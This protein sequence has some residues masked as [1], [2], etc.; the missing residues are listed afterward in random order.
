MKRT[1]QRKVILITGCS[2]GFGFLMAARLAAQGH[3][4]IATMRDISKKDALLVEAE[5]R[6]GTS[7]LA[8][9]ALDVT[10]PKTVRSALSRI[11]EQYGF[12]DV[13]INNAGVGMMGFFEDA[14]EEDFRFL[15]EVNFFGVLNVLREILPVMRQHGKG[16]IINISSVSAFFGS[17]GNSTYCSSKWALERFSESLYLELAPLGIKVN[18]VEP[19]SYHTRIFEENSHFVKNFDNK[20]SFYYKV[21]QQLKASVEQYMK[22]LDKDPEEVAELVEQI[23]EGQRTSFRNVIG[24]RS[25]VRYWLLKLM[26][27]ESFARRAYKPTY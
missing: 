22:T 10:D 25:N 4:V 14:L 21:S 11:R 9:L 20:D 2:S 17:A 18:L 15:F 19:G 7:N 12:V 8:V 5:K 13:V 6:G 26:S 24:F 1:V 27:F 16:Q 3:Q 23:V